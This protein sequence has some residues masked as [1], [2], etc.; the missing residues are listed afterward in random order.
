MVFD[1]TVDGF[2]KVNLQRGKEKEDHST[3]VRIRLKN[4]EAQVVNLGNR[5]NLTTLDLQKGDE[6]R[7]SGKTQRV[8]D[9]EVLT[10]DRVTVEDQTF[11]I[12]HDSGPPA[13]IEGTVR[14]FAKTSIDGAKEKNLLIRLE[15]ENGRNCVVDLGKGTE[16]SQ[17]DLKPGSDIRLEGERT[18]VDGKALIL[19]R[20]IRVD[21]ETTRLHDRGNS[22]PAAGETR[23]SDRRYDSTT[24]PV[25]TP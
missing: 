18:E 14:E 12:R 16:L 7:V 6:I 9:R 1:G 3:F 22:D 23:E 15:L 13:I 10:A 21:D 17:L 2:K 24:D 25:S 4:G 20:K 19:A 8:D 11:R 5:V